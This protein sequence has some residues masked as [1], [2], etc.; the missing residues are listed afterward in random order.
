VFPA[1][2]N[3]S[4][5]FDLG[6]RSA[7]SDER[8]MSDQDLLSREQNWVYER[9][10]HVQALFQQIGSTALQLT[11]VLRWKAVGPILSAIIGTG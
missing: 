8:H 11:V 3:I 6:D 1:V 7:K 5:I 10:S 4:M 9:Q 2:E